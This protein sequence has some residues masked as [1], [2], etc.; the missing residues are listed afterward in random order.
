ME[1]VYADITL[2]NLYDRMSYEHGYSKD[3]EVRQITVRARV[4]T[5]VMTLVINEA[6]WQKLGLNSRY[7][8]TATLAKGIRAKCEKTDAV[9]MHW[10]DRSSVLDAVI[11]DVDDVILGRLPLMDMDLIADP[12]SHELVGAHGDKP[13]HFDYTIL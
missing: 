8:C 6:I 3:P 10:K 11:A 4:D 7:P 13:M 5:D 12:V 2:K 9:E 1:T